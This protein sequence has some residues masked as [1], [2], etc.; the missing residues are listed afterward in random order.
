MTAYDWLNK[1]EYPF[2]AH[3]LPLDAGRMHYVDEGVGRPIVMAHGNPTWSFMYRHLI[4]GLSDTHR[5]V[6]VD[7][8]GFGLSDKPYNWT[9]RPEDHANNLRA[10]IDSLELKDITFVIHDWGGPIGMWYAVNNPDNIHSL[11][12]FNTFMWPVEPRLMVRLFSGILGGPIGRYFIEKHNFFAGRLMKFAAHDKAKFAR[13]HDH[14]TQPLATPQD[15]KGSW[16]FPR[17][18]LGSRQWLEQIW[19]KR[20]AIADKSALFLWGMEDRAFREDDLNRWTALIKDHTV[21]KLDASHYV[22][23]D[24]GE[25]LL[26]YIRDF[27]T[28]H[29]S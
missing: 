22:A 15:R 11:I 19:D 21:H 16:V 14:Y 28:A 13:V 8:L 6:A 29:E 9:Y 1:E 5:C 23:E 2:E 24:M 3:Y 7:Y 27:L 20:D 12:V 17:E 10:L 18:I 25:A 26:P 4:K